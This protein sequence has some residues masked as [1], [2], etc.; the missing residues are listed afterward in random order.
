M[1]FP[2]VF[3]KLPLM[4]GFLTRAKATGYDRRG[5]TVLCKVDKHP[6]SKKG[7]K[8]GSGAEPPLSKKVN[9]PEI[10]TRVRGWSD[11]EEESAW[12]ESD[13]GRHENNIQFSGAEAEEGAL[14]KRV[15]FTE[16]AAEEF[17]IW[18][19]EDTLPNQE[20]W[21]NSVQ[22]ALRSER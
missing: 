13:E 1:A 7:A 11:M 12:M 14:L 2:F 5:R 20:V 15:H 17:D 18:D 21:K 19:M 10:E 22:K 4:G 3:F 6:L 8:M 9:F 16:A